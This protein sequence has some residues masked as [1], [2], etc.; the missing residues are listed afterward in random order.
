[1]RIREEIDL[2]EVLVPVLDKELLAY[3]GLGDHALENL[4]D[5]GA[6]RA[7]ETGVAPGDHIGHDPALPVGRPGERG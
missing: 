3:A 4:T 2:L 5:R 6:L 7:A 1:V